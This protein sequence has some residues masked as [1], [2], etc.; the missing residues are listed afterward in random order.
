MSST[1]LIQWSLLTSQKLLTWLITRS[2]LRSLFIWEPFCHGCVI[3]SMN[4]CNI[5]DIIRHCQTIKSWKGVSSGYKSW[6]LGISNHYQWCCHRYCPQ[7]VDDL[8][9]A[10][11]RS[12]PTSN[13]LQGFDDFSKWT[14]DNKLSL[15]PNKCQALQVCFKTDV[16]LQ[17]GIKLFLSQE[18]DFSW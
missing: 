12:H 1:T 4:E 16:P 2:W 13:K 6:S 11:N 15:N 17:G 3:S 14:T 5:C 10:E 18:Q 7:Y 8:I 9:P